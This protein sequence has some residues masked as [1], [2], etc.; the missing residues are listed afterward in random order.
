MKDWH[1]VDQISAQEVIRSTGDIEYHA[2]AE[3]RFEKQVEDYG[4]WVKLSTE[5]AKFKGMLVVVQSACAHLPDWTEAGEDFHVQ[6]KS[7]CLVAQYRKLGLAK[8]FGEE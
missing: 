2:A 1:P 7:V 5:T 6:P 8:L 4:G 3:A